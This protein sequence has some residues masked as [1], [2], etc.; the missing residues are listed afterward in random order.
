MLYARVIFIQLLVQFYHLIMA[1]T[2]TDLLIIIITEGFGPSR[3]DV[4]TWVLC[5]KCVLKRLM[6]WLC[7]SL[8]TYVMK[9]KCTTGKSA[10]FVQLQNEQLLTIDCTP[11]TRNVYVATK[12][13][14]GNWSIANVRIY[15]GYYRYK[16]KLV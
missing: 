15:C 11:W 16:V 2:V 3:T 7:Q 6:I 8:T 14:M 5:L 4:F 10:C 9:Q 1:S 12:F 13:A